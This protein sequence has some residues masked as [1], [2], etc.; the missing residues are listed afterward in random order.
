MPD[1]VHGS[2]RLGGPQAAHSLPPCLTWEGRRGSWRSL[3]PSCPRLQASLH[4]CAAAL[5]AFLM[6]VRNGGSEMLRDLPRGTQ[7]ERCPGIFQGRE[8]GTF[9]DSLLA[10]FSGESRGCASRTPRAGSS[11]LSRGGIGG[12]GEFLCL[13]FLSVHSVCLCLCL[14]VCL[15]GCA[16]LSLSVSL[17]LFSA[18][19]CSLS[20]SSSFPVCS[21][22]ESSNMPRAWHLRRHSLLASDAVLA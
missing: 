20:L 2:W 16:S 4:T 10:A 7:P 1:S 21:L 6:Q 14:C 11:G 3:N 13:C 5:G 22:G 12:P 8:A 15:G 17:S 9:S 19:L 18:F